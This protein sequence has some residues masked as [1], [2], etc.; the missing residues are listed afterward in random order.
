MLTATSKDSKKEEELGLARYSL[1][2]LLDANR[3]L[4]RAK[5]DVRADERAGFAPP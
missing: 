2:A 1:E 3:E 5:L 4:T